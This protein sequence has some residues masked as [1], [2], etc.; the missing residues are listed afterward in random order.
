MGWDDDCASHL[1]KSVRCKENNVYNYCPF[2]TIISDSKGLIDCIND[3]FKYFC[4]PNYLKVI[5]FTDNYDCLKISANSTMLI[6]TKYNFIFKHESSGYGNLWEI[7]K[8]QKGKFH[9]EM[10]NYSEFIK[11]YENRIQNFKN[12]L[13]G[14]YEVLFIIRKIN[15]NSK[16]NIELENKIKEKYP[17][18]KFSFQLQE[19]PHIRMFNEGLNLQNIIR[20][21]K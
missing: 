21:I 7:E 17:N 15:N 3:D 20:N 6:H 11:R 9:F 10:D 18:L 4:D 14:K 16:T 8:W 19:E 5:T 2:D 1:S 12:Y 13:N